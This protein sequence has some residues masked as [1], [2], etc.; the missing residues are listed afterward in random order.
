MP[1]E[2]SEQ[3]SPLYEIIGRMNIP[4]ISLDGYEA[5]DL[6]GTIARKAESEDFHT[7]IVTGD[8]D[9]MQLVSDDIFVYSPGNRFKPTTTYTI[10]KVKDRW[11]VLPTEFIDY[12]A[13]VGDSSD[14]I[15]GVDGIGAKSAVKLL[16]EYKELEQILENGSNI[17]NKRIR[18][19]ILNGKDLAYL[20]KKLVTIDCYAPYEFHLEN[21]IVKDPDHE[22]LAVIFQDLELNTLINKISILG[23]GNNQ[24]VEAIV[25]KEYHLI[26]S[27]SKL[28]SII[29]ILDSSP[30]ISFDIISESRDY[31][32][33][34]IDYI[35]L[36]VSSDS[37]WC[38]PIE[39]DGEND[40]LNLDFLQSI[41][42][43]F[44]ND[45]FVLSYKYNQEQDKKSH[46]NFIA[47]RY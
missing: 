6:I 19:G 36:S 22:V 28:K 44:E 2:L 37:G 16:K 11:G 41:K 9:M 25:E 12:L 29:P 46:S 47:L 33:K 27:V 10:D 31:K 26:D 17:N 13:M 34:I 20:S 8:K 14:N 30:L 15:P 45:K 23:S 24:S 1:E 35:S 3:L 43:I 42:T 5:D 40:F 4:L 21:F 39:N 38:I 18:E 32:S 7:Y